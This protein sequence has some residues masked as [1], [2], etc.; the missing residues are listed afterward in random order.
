[1]GRSLNSHR[2]PPSAYRQRG[3]VLL[4]IMLVTMTFGGY[5]GVR[6]LN[7]AMARS[8][9]N[10]L[11]S[12][13]ILASARQALLAWS[14]TT[15]NSLPSATVS[16]LFGLRAFRPGN[17]PYPDLATGLTSTTPSDGLRDLGCART[18]WAG[19]GTLRPITASLTT[20]QKTNIRCFG[21]LPV[22]TLGLESV[23]GSSA[24]VSGRWPW[25]VV[26]ANLVNINQDCPTRLDSTITNTALATGTNACGNINTPTAPFQWITVLDEYGAVRS[27]RVAA[28]IIL[29][30]EVT[31]RQPGNVRQTRSATAL[32]TAFLD[33]VDNAACT[34]GRCDNGRL[35]STP[36]TFIQCTKPT[37]TTGD[38]RFSANYACNDR[39]VYITVDEL[40]GYAAKRIEREFVTCLAEYA[41]NNANRYPWAALAGSPSSVSVGQTSGSFPSNDAGATPTCANQQIYW[42]GWQR[43]ATYTVAADQSSA[44]FSFASLIG[45]P[46]VSVP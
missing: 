17:L 24:D 37:S 30:G 15:D 3:V 6:A 11:E 8:N 19:F 5:F 4:V 26:S 39:L 29:P 18:T 35:N 40:F 13:R 44:Q 22:A 38:S 9:I 16:G 21:R 46:A 31:T 28:V 14:V 42:G 41:Q 20:T 23:A 25:Y 1:M 43:A 32:P 2:F 27:T 12:E 36:L 7:S 45:R 10:E 33:T 34:G